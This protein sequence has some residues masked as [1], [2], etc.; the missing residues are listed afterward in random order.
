MKRTTAIM[1]G[2][3]V[4]IIGM[5][6]LSND[7][8]PSTV[9][10]PPPQ[11]T[12]DAPTI[13][14]WYQGGTLHKKGVLDWQRANAEDKLATCSDFVAAMWKQ[15]NF[16]PRIQDSMNSISDMKPYALELVAFMD[17]ATKKRENSDENDR[18]FANQTVSSMATMGMISMGW[19]K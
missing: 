8:A 2:G 16:I 17:A 15:G 11:S 19:L 14:Q 12:S 1:I 4:V 10:S 3:G 9:E 7:P 18:I 5:I 6:G 13:R